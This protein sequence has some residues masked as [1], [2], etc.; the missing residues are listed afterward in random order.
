MKFVNG[1]SIPNEI[2]GVLKYSNSFFLDNHATTI[3]L[4]EF[5][6]KN[7][8]GLKCCLLAECNKMETIIDGE[9]HCEGNEDYSVEN[10]VL[11]SLEYLGIYYMDNLRS[12]AI[13]VHQQ[14]RKTVM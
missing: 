8:K 2:K 14:L 9:R 5:G 3:N 6:V 1:E 10:D 12:M 7:M 4:S 13:Y 11:R